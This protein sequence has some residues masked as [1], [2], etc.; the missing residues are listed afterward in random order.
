MNLRLPLSFI[1]LL[2]DGLRMQLDLN[3][4]HVD[5]YRIE[6]LILE[7]F[8]LCHP[9]FSKFDKICSLTYWHYIS[10]LG[11]VVWAHLSFYIF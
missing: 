10:T 6:Q 11:N 5:K 1:V 3:L 4:T 8:N 2:I 9:S 7:C